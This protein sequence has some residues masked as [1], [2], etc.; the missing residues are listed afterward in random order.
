MST[1]AHALRGPDSLADLWRALSDPTRRSILELLRSAPQTT[2]EI[3]KAFPQSRFAVMKHLDVLTGAGLVVVRRK[4]RERWNYLNAVPLQRL[5]ESWVKPYEAAWAKSLIRFK[6]AA[7]QQ[8]QEMS[9]LTLAEPA[10]ARVLTLELEIP[11]EAPRDKVW[12]M[13][14]EEVHQWW[15]R[16]FYASANP[17][18][19]RFETK[20]GG[21]LYEE[22]EDGG[23]VIWYTVIAVTPGVSVD[24]A[25]HLTSAFGGPAQTLLR[26]ALREQ[27]ESTVL[28]LSDAVVGNV[29]DRTAA[30]LEE[31]W[32][33]LFETG[34]KQFTESNREQ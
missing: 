22:S 1:K 3:A 21:R 2:G 18:A 28:E 9:M 32:R 13:L 5:Y 10:A 20:L 29:G 11:I 24:L 31:G 14:T 23:G 16:D 33:A 27:G 4:G 8:P 26:L 15:P 30:T 25:G 6:D 34:L 17:K 7:E 12:R 19:M